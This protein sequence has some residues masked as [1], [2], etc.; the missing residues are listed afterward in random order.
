MSTVPEDNGMSFAVKSHSPKT[1]T[2]KGKGKIVKPL[3]VAMLVIVPTAFVLAGCTEKTNPLATPADQLMNA[4]AASANLSKNGPLLHSVQGGFWFDIYGN[5]KKV[6]NT[7]GAHQYVDGSFGGRYLVNAANAYDHVRWV[8]AYSRVLFLKVYDDVPGYEKFAVVGG[9]E[10]TGP[11]KGYFEVWWLA[12]A[13]G[14]GNIVTADGFY[15]DLDS[16][17]VAK[18]WV[19]P[20]DQLMQLPGLSPSLPASGGSLRIE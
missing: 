9:V 8:N 11:G 19:L 12:L 16:S 5:G 18:A 10:T 1:S 20:P 6:Q 2:N 13:T 15:Y 3:S 14:T 17:I 7:I 4:P